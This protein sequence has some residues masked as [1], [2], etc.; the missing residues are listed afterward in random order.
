MD[1][2]SQEIEQLFSENES[3]S[4]KETP[5]QTWGKNKKNIAWWEESSTE[6]GES[7]ESGESE[8]SEEIEESAENEQSDESTASEEGTVS[9]EGGE[10]AGSAE[11]NLAVIKWNT[12][13]ACECGAR[14]KPNSIGMHQK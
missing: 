3:I 6:S 2:T 5:P 1:V 9:E 13:F 8:G 7:G 4:S 10:S 14:L 11:S 12:K